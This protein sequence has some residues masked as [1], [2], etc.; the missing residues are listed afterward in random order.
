MNLRQYQ[1]GTLLGLQ[2]V[3]SALVSQKLEGS[4]MR[5]GYARVST[6]EQCLDS[7]LKNLKAAGCECVFKDHGVSGAARSRP[8]LERALACLQK[9]DVLVVQR[10]DRLARSL[11]NFLDLIAKLSSRG[12]AI[13][14][15]SEAIETE[16]AAGR[17]TVH[18]LAA[19][20]EFERDLISERTISGLAGARARGARIGRPKALSDEHL[21]LAA[22]LR[23][24][25]FSVTEIAR[26]VGVGRST[27]Y[28]TM[29]PDLARV[30][31]KAKSSSGV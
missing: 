10:L 16:T 12:A 21:E 30:P 31:L 6:Q 11:R 18:L 29:R 26:V 17:L 9:G 20:G 24:S 14:S 4:C 25:G 28:R 22:N 5:I 23:A 1:K 15:L 27:L 19:L 8:E 2:T 3:R 7:Q 13:H